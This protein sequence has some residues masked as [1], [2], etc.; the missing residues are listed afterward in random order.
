MAGAIYYR[1]SVIQI[2]DRS[3]DVAPST[4]YDVTKEVSDWHL[5]VGADVIHILLHSL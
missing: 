4:F 3:E 2:V 5:G 1:W